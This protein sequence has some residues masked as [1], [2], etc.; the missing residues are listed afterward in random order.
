VSTGYSNSDNAGSETSDEVTINRHKYLTERRPQRMP[1][2]DVTSVYAE[3]DK[4]STSE[5]QDSRRGSG[6]DGDTGSRRR[7]L[8]PTT[9]ISGRVSEGERRR[10]MSTMHEKHKKGCD[11][12]RQP[13]VSTGVVVQVV[14]LIQASVVVS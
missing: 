12:W 3:S 13:R 6:T 11:G 5:L 10:K 14:T 7:R 4:L 2:D 9:A 1:V 8:S